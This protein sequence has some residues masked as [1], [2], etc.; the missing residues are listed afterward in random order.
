MLVHATQ[1]LQPVNVIAVSRITY[2]VSTY[3]LMT[4]EA[5]YIKSI[6]P[7]INTKDEYRSRALTIKISFIHFGFTNFLFC[8]FF[9]TLLYVGVDNV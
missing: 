8:S 6:K 3:H 1:L 9:A 4:L 2:H 7:S 5:L